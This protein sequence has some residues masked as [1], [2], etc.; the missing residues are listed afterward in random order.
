MENFEKEGKAEFWEDEYGSGILDRVEGG[1]T[2]RPPGDCG[3][4]FYVSTW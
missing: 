1:E 4:Q 2:A 3:G